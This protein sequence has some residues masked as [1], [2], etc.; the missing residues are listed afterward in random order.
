MRIK[1]VL[2]QNVIR[3]YRLIWR[4]CSLAL[5]YKLVV[6][7]GNKKLCDSYDSV[8]ILDQVDIISSGI[9]NSYNVYHNT[10]VLVQKPTLPENS[11]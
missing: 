1:G 7:F 10:D 4:Q 11:R 8:W 9:N 2:E 6:I 3:L 5:Q